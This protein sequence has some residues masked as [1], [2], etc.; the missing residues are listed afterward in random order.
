MINIKNIK[1]NICKETNK[2]NT[3]NNEFYKCFECNINICP[4][5]KLKHNKEHNIINYD[6]IHYICNKHESEKFVNYCDKLK[7]NAFSLCDKEHLNHKK[8]SIIDILLDK[9]ELLIKLDELKN[10]N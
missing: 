4:L 7:I 6:I 2:Y 3:Y 5:Y 8:F 9:E 10:I 1:C